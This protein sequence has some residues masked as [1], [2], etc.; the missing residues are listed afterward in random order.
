MA[1]QKV[2]DSSGFSHAELQSFS[3]NLFTWRVIVKHT[4]SGFYCNP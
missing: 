3:F 2:L 1:L 4:E